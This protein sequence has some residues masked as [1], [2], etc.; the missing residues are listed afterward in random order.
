MDKKIEPLFHTFDVD[1]DGYVH[2]YLRIVTNDDIDQVELDAELRMLMQ[3]LFDE[4]KLGSIELNKENFIEACKDL[5]K[6][7]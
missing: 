3:P 7:V 5:I 6:V 2:Y 4:A 1:G